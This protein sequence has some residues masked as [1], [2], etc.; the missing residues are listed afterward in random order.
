VAGDI[1]DSFAERSNTASLCSHMCARSC[2]QG[3]T[4]RLLDTFDMY[5]SVMD[6]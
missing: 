1:G 5:V 4:S 6:M 3:N 2:V